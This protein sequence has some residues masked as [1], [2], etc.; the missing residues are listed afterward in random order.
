MDRIPPIMR[1]QIRLE[2]MLLAAMDYGREHPDECGGVRWARNPVRVV[3]LATAHLDD[4]Q[5]AL[6]DLVEHP[7]LVEVRRCRHTERQIQS[8][9]AEVTRQLRGGRDEELHVTSW[10]PDTGWG[11]HVTIWPWSDEAAE[12]VRNELAP[13]PIEIEE[14]AP[15]VPLG[16]DLSSQATQRVD[17]ERGGSGQDV[18]TSGP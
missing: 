8:W 1:E 10:G 6:E 3:F 18:T 16:G 15:G 13:I 4:H 9:L 2:P 17:V 7:E 12:R 11:I 5:R 14:M